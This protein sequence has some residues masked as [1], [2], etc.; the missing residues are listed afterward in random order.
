MYAITTTAT[1]HGV[2][3]FLISVEARL[4]SGLPK[5][6][7]VGL[8]DAAVREGVER[9]RAALRDTF[10][11]F[12][13]GPCIVNLSPASRRKAGS[14]FDLAMA[15]AI[16]A[17]MG[18]VEPEAVAAAVFVGELG[19]DG[20]LKSAA[21]TLP[22]TIA[23][24]RAGR[25]RIIVPTASAR[26]ASVIAGIDVLAAASFADALRL[27]REGYR[28]TPVRTDPEALLANAAI[29]EGLDLAD[30]RGLYQPKRALELAAAGN[31]HTLF[32][33]PPGAGKTMLARRLAPLL[34][35]LSVGEAIETT[36]IHSIAGLIADT[37]LMVRRPF[38]A[39]HHTTS[40]AGLV[41]GGSFPSPGE[42]SLAHNGVLFLDEL[43]E[44]VPS[45]LNQLREP[46]E[47]KHLTI[48]RAGA[49][50]TF[51]A[52]FL[53]VAAMNPCPC[54]YHGTGMRECRCND[55]V[56]ARYQGRLSGPL[57]DRIDLH[58]EVPCIDV[59]ELRSSRQEEGSAT[60][61]QRIASARE[62]RL[63][64][65]PLPLSAGAADRLALAARKFAMSTRAIERS[66]AVARTVAHLAGA[67]EVSAA[68]LDEA[69][70]F[71]STR[72]R[73]HACALSLAGPSGR[74]GEHDAR[75]RAGRGRAV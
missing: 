55:G 46:L 13:N 56:V 51:P 70:Q 19:L 62:H 7:I 11:E 48:S 53:L 63:R 50:L 14:A 16:A 65:G 29:E 32:Y 67:T 8:P 75:D 40:G 61:R 6:L 26:E 15:M 38:R 44:F 45:V 35:A 59:E 10:G 54:G 21:G 2:D 66:T 57:L 71:R 3:S 31:H 43:P 64:F 4:S 18:K 37:S 68:H 1:H 74:E 27:V 42:I 9:V 22:A 5:F 41:G 17:A 34:P 58:V 25:A 28:D 60:V 39:P 20:S 36:A 73:D 72:E 30:V 49:R 12:H 52:A 47:D 33:G 24:A 69:L 23:A